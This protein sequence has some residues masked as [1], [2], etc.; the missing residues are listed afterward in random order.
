MV[1]VT[2]V[3]WFDAD[4]DEAIALYR[5]AFPDLR[6]VQEGRMP[7]GSLQ[8]AAIEFA[9]QRL[10]LLNGG[11]GHPHSDAFSLMI[12]CEGQAEVDRLWDALLA[13]GGTPGPCGWLT[14]RFGV[15]WQVV[16]TRFVE[17]TSDP[18]P[19]RVQRVIQAMLAMSKFD[20]AQLE[21]AAAG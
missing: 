19:A 17:L 15:S 3:L 6:V 1:T 8:T 18:D 4:A 16:P 2:P 10:A 9:D 12:T 20:I 7:D 5:L 11:P 21:A 14:D 13:G